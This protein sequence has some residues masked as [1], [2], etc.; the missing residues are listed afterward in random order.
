MKKFVAF[1]VLLLVAAAPLAQA[2]EGSGPL[3]WIAFE[4]TKPGKSRDLIKATIEQDG[5]M[6]D[7][8]VTDGTLLSWGIAI[9]I[10]HRLSDDWNYLLWAN[11]AGWGGVGGLQKGFEKKFASMTPEEMVQSQRAYQEATVEGSHHDWIVRHEIFRASTSDTVPRYFDVGYYMAE[12]GQEMA[13][14]EFFKSTIAPIYEKL[15][16]D[17]VIT[18]FG[19]YTQEL[20]G[21]PG[22]THVMWVTMADLAAKDTADQIFMASL[23]EEQMKAGMAL[24]DWQSHWDQVLLI[25]HLGGMP[26]A[27]E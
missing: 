10:N 5:P 3:T 12:P 23:T 9:P 17:G 26:S 27:G 16:T 11:M 25:V 1:A 14:T 19:V 4:K 8:L 13:L 6:Y 15:L 24:V 22:W 18:G 7:E 2:Q 21:E 20:H